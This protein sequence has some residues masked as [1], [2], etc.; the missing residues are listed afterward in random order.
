M[1]DGK[2]VYTFEGNADDLL[3]A[4][5]QLEKALGVLAAQAKKTDQAV[6]GVAESGKKVKKGLDPAG[7]AMKKVGGL[8]KKFDAGIH[9][10]IG[11]LG[12]LSSSLGGVV[13][14][15]AAV[16]GPAALAVAALGAVALAVGAVGVGMIQA[17]FA[18]DELNKELKKFEGQEGFEPIDKDALKSIET[19]NNSLGALTAVFQRLVVEVGANVAPVIEE[20][21]VTLV[22]F[23][24][25]GLD[26]FK[27]FAEGKN[28]LF[29][30]ANFLVK[31]FLKALIAPIDGIMNLIWAMGKLATAVG[32][33][34]L[35]E[36]LTS[37]YDAYDNFVGG[38]SRSITGG[39]FGALGSGLKAVGGATSD[40]DQRAR[41]LIK[42]V[43]I[44][45]EAIKKHASAI[46]GL[47]AVLKKL[48]ASVEQAEVSL[49]RIRKANL[50]AL[51]PL[52]KARGEYFET[53]TELDKLEKSTR[54]QIT[55]LT[56]QIENA[57]RLGLSEEALNDA[58]NARFA[59]LDNLV[60]IED[61]RLETLEKF[62]REAVSAAENER[63]LSHAINMSVRGREKYADALAVQLDNLAELAEKEKEQNGESER[64]V[65]LLNE[66]SEKQEVLNAATEEQLE[67]EGI[68]NEKRGEWLEERFERQQ[69]IWKAEEEAE[70]ALHEKR[71]GYLENA[72][73]AINAYS[74]MFGAV[75]DF[76]LTQNEEL[77]EGQKRSLMTLYRLQQ[78]SAVASIIV[79]T[80]TA[81]VKALAQLGP[82]AGGAAGAAIAVTGA[83]Q[84][85]AVLAAPPP[86][87]T[88]GTVYDT[89]GVI[90][91]SGVMIN[92]LPGESVLSREATARLGEKGVNDLNSG[93]GGKSPIVVEMVYKHKIFDTFVSDN[94]NKGGPLDSAITGNRRVGRSGR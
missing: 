25:M 38:I 39:V 7:A 49:E 66:I 54:K 22:K 44:T 45:D 12:G 81:I 67:L 92:A 71:M 58:V 18:A 85:G 5:S 17:V 75:M 24:L 37:A 1:A 32:A 62:N 89:G 55:A 29:E 42:T 33:T 88:G 86:F 82:I 51:S 2:T 61:Q 50:A 48:V 90:P 43:G 15:L 28:L 70:A 53:R 30:F 63:E 10:T 78:A 91:G 16:S 93:M 26:A 64:Y 69:E 77:T 73:S 19:V 27:K 72:A 83:V 20:L 84:I 87:H 14:S 52:A 21:S 79:D 68:A 56:E 74:D 4:I 94:I 35:G 47:L 36:S 46:K 3:S 8:L 6:D 11:K 59:A 9:G 34:G 65:E 57:E 80:A 31:T 23:G 40:Y 76:M 41:D 60:T 13:G